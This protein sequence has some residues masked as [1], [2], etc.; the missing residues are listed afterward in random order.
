MAL[1]LLVGGFIYS[2]ARGET[3]ISFH[4]KEGGRG[5]GEDE[6]EEEGV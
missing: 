5:R 2:F 4:L 6:A 1:S 3:L